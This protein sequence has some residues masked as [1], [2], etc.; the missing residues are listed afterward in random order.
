MDPIQPVGVPKT[1]GYSKFKLIRDLLVVAALVWIGFQ[2]YWGYFK[3]KIWFAGF[4]TGAFWVTGLIMGFVYF[5]SV[6]KIHERIKGLP[7]GAKK[8]TAYAGFSLSLLVLNP[9][10]LSLV[11]WLFTPP[12]ALNTAGHWFFIGCAIAGGLVLLLE[13]IFAKKI[14]EK[15]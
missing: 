13:R 7:Q 15:I 3:F 10:P 14:P 12:G 6:H 11:V 8:F 1:K 2:A 4:G 5:Y 9:L